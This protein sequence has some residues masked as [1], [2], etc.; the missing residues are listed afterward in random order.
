MQPVQHPSFREALVFWLKLG[1]I[2]FGGPAGQIAIMHEFLVE[3]KRWISPSRFLHALNYC[4]LLPGPEAQQLATYTGWLL[5]GVRGGLAAGILFILPSVFILLG[6]SIAYAEFGSVAWV[7]ALFYGLK[8]AVVTIIALALYR[9]GRASLR[10]FVPVG[11][12]VG[13]FLA[14]AV[15]G[16][17]FPYIIL[18]VLGFGLLMRFIAPE[19]ASRENLVRQVAEEDTY[20]LNSVVVQRETH[21]DWPRLFTAVGIAVFLWL[22]PFLLLTIWA[23]DVD[24]WQ[25]LISFFT[26]AAFVTFGG[27]YAVLPYIA[28]VSVERF[29]WLTRLQMI[30]GLALGETTP[31]PLV[32]VLA[33]VGFM[34]GYNHFGGS[35]AYGSLGLLITTYYTFLP[36]F[37]FVF[38][39]APFIERT[40]GEGKLHSVLRFVTAAVVG[41][42]ANLALYFGKVVLFPGGLSVAGIDWFAVVWVGISV[43]ALYRFQVRMPLWIAVSAVAGLLYSRL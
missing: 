1:C 36:C 21:T 32:M 42:M 37:L 43:V 31:G 39:G 13:S 40:Y 23:P 26:R 19:Y 11:L 9:I 2:S 33:F 16:I 28:Q 14:L 24:F 22:L 10:G 15:F 12:A 8:P 41:V 20:L 34:G 4:M 5:H 25:T 35:I 6:L 38:A 7:A 3:K 27:A 18:G 29:G 30:D 17:P